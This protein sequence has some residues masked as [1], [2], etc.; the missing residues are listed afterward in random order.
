LYIA[1]ARAFARLSLNTTS[2]STGLATPPVAVIEDGTAEIAGE[3]AGEGHLFER[4]AA[5][6]RD[7]VVEDRGAQTRAIG[8]ER[9]PAQSRTALVSAAGALAVQAGASSQLDIE[10]VARR[11]DEAVEHG[12]RGDR[13]GCGGAVHED[14]AA[15]VRTLDIGDAFG[16]VIVVD[17][18]VVAVDIAGKDRDIGRG[19]AR[20]A[21]DFRAVEA[22]ID[23][24]ARTNVETDARVGVGRR[25]IHAGP[26]PDFSARRHRQRGWQR[27]RL[28]TPVAAVADGRAEVGDAA[29]VGMHAR[30][31]HHGRE[32]QRGR[33]ARGVDAQH[34]LTDGGNRRGIRS[35]GTTRHRGVPCSGSKGTSTTP[36]REAY[37]S[38]KAIVQGTRRDGSRVRSGWAFI[39][40]H[41]GSIACSI[42]SVQ[43]N[44]AFKALLIKPGASTPAKRMSVVVKRFH[45]ARCLSGSGF[46]RSPAKVARVM[47][48]RMRVPSA[49][50]STSSNAWRGVAYLPLGLNNREPTA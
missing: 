45:G 9:E 2:V 44:G 36:R 14:H 50:T 15:A 35:N 21:R 5:R 42:T 12:A 19:I 49:R 25:R 31:P 18:G 28:G 7:A 41:D 1:P 38:R 6:A 34:A 48:G 16:D 17:V 23:R 37:P 27:Q 8:H 43:I 24:H 10:V 47:N 33:Q 11:H 40:H 3:V 26:Y 32:R 20:I 13:P 4:G 22:A 39:A 30:R 46:R 29:G